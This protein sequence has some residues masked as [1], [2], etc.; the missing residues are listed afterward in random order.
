MSLPAGPRALRV[1]A[2]ARGSAAAAAAGR[3]DI[4][5]ALG[6]SLG[7]NVL[8][9]HGGVEEVWL[10]RERLSHPPGLPRAYWTLKRRLSP[11]HHAVLSV[12]RRQYADP[13]VLRFVA[14]SRAIRDSMVEVHGVDPARV[15]VVP[16][17]VDPAR[18]RPPADAG[19]KAELRRRLGL[20][21]DRAVLLFVGNNFRLKGL[22]PLVRALALL[23]PEAPPFLLAVL[24]RGRPGRYRRLARRL[25]AGGLVEF[26]GAVPG[27][28]GWYRAGDAL[29]HP[30]Y[31]D[32][33]SLVL[34]EARASGLP[35]LASR[36]DGSSEAVEDGVDGVVVEEPGDVPVLARRIRPLLDPAFRQRAG[37][38]ARARSLAVPPAD[39][40]ADMLRVYEEALAARG[41]RRG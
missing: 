36:W 32:A 3:F 39:P 30:T 28:D 24:G 21:A 23:A 29:L 13:A 25:G 2:F 10:R 26:R 20:P 15:A 5:H 33:A 8:N 1:L 37:A 40:A 31:H 38:S 6:K 14:L 19:E 41:A 27:I 11:R 22:E 17:R 18:F 4:V 9:P 16:N 34:L 35:V 7:M 12:I